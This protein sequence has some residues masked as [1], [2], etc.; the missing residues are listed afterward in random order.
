MM[1]RRPLPNGPLKLAAVSTVS[2]SA[3]NVGYLSSF[4]VPLRN[5]ARASSA[6]HEFALV[7]GTKLDDVIARGAKDGERFV[8]LF[9]GEFSSEAST[10]DA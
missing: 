6:R 1:Q 7:I 5:H 9:P 4:S 2:T 3:L 10:R 8:D